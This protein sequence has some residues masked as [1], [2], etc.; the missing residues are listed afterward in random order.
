MRAFQ[1]HDALTQM[2]ATTHLYTI[3]GMHCAGC[4]AKVEQAV[5]GVDGVVSC[6]VDLLGQRAR[7]TGDQLDHTQVSEAI[8]RLGFQGALITD[9]TA[10]VQPTSAGW[11]SV[12][13]A[14]AGTV[15]TAV[16]AHAPLAIPERGWIATGLA[17]AVVV[18]AGRS[19]LWRGLTSLA[20]LRPDMDSLIALGAGAAIGGSI[21][22]HAGAVS[23]GVHA[24]AGAMIISFVLLGRALEQRARRRGD[25]AIEALLAR[26]PDEAVVIDG[27][28]RQFKTA[29]S[30]L[31]PG[32][33]VLVR[34]GD[35]IPVDGRVV[36][37][38]AQVDES[39]F[40]GEAVPVPHTVEHQVLGGSVVSDG[41]LRLTVTA[42]GADAALGR[43][44]ELVRQ[45]RATKAPIA[46]QADRLAAVFV[47]LV[48]VIALATLIGWGLL[49]GVSGWQTGA[50]AAVAVL[51]VAC[52]C[53]LGLATPTAIAVAL[54]RA[55]QHG[56]LIR[57]AAALETAG[58]VT[59]IGIDKTGTLTTGA[60]RLV[61]IVV[62]DSKLQSHDL[63]RLAA[64]A[65]RGSRH[66]YADAIR[67]AVDECGIVTDR[68]ER[69]RETVGAGVSGHIEGHDI[70]V[71]APSLLAQHQVDD[72]ALGAVYQQAQQRGRS[73]AAVAIDGVASGAF[74][75]QDRLRADATAT[76]ARL[77][78][79]GL[80]VHLWS[81]DQAGVVTA[82][83]A[84]VGI[85]SAEGGLTPADKLERVT[86]LEAAGQRV[87][88]VGDGINDAP[89]IGGASL[90][91]AL[92]SGSDVAANAA[93]ITITG[94]RLAVL[95]DAVDLGRVTIGRIRQNLT[96]AL[97]YNVLAIPTAAGLALPLTGHLL[98]P[99]WAAAAMAGSS[100]LVV[101]NS[102]RLNRWQ[103]QPATT[104]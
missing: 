38:Q 32:H 2:T 104:D 47:P 17:A 71:G 92:A 73:V 45:A 68:I 39:M 80:A 99:G 96:L 67:A 102:L 8:A 89:A 98:N 65:E 35:A 87:A 22:A 72:A 64:G 61:D 69:D 101:G 46:R 66:P 103:P 88:M 97:A 29:V 31:V 14:A 55:S 90:G 40:T 78:Q 10:T 20:C 81:G 11:T 100:L 6:A 83:G 70:L 41:W 1:P 86:A 75:F 28:G 85:T 95:A 63:L 91:V 30:D 60:V 23:F 34:A 50:A 94:G 15:A 43:V 48:V 33:E 3:T 9:H 37:G 56:L 82:T 52:P 12:V 77:H 59:A 84:A 16:V 13:L 49:G 53:A 26:T 19:I 4:V 36:E 51:V 62:L 74:I 58:R 5:G 93:A 57:D 42:V 21:A 25:Q 7:I 79:A 54:G 24:L 27:K 44:A 18:L 76:V